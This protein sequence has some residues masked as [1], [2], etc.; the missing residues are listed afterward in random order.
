MALWQAM[1]QRE[2]IFANRRLLPRRLPDLL[3]RAL[4]AGT[5]DTPRG[6]RDGLVIAN[7][8]GYLAS[9]SSLSYAVTYALQDA[10]GL[11]V[12]VWGNIVSAIMTA[13]V[14]A[15]HR[16][17]KAAGAMFLTVTLFTTLFYFT[18]ILGRTSGIQLN[19]IGAAAIAFVVLGLEQMRLVLVVLVGAAGLHLGAW[20]LYPRPQ[21]GI[22]IAPWLLDQLYFFSVI[23]IMAIIGVVIY[24]AF[25][26][27]RDAR[28]RSDALLLNILPEMIAERLKAEPD[29]TIADLHD[30]ATV[31]FADM[32]G[33][34][35]LSARLGPQRIVE[36]LDELFSAFDAIAADLG[37]EKIKTIGDAYM[38]VAGVPVA[39]ENHADA[40]ADLALGMV[41]A[42]RDMAA[43]HDLDIQIRVGIATGPVLA[44]VIGRTKFAY[45][46]WGG[47][48]NLAARLESNG[49]P[50]STLVNDAAHNLLSNEFQLTEYGTLDLKGLGPTHAWRLEGRK[51]LARPDVMRHG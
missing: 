7:I 48:V 12:L 35:Q 46:V 40:A 15:M 49:S 37:V 1:K 42:S 6:Q 3:R 19:Y 27:V 2:T 25:T 4:Y 50:G 26:L 38:V 8:V 9:L 39:H 21:A 36:L 14:P 44:G 18:S 10:T 24:Y 34:T 20:F 45:D 47:T 29:R 33:F 51:E 41:R 43:R 31:L 22:D 13:C 16:F 23:S 11:A 32:T 28:A 17:G 5:H 30:E